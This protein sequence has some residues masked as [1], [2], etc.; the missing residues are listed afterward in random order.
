ME[1]RLQFDAAREGL[2]V[3]LAGI[4]P[5]GLAALRADAARETSGGNDRGCAGLH[6]RGPDAGAGGRTRCGPRR[7][8]RVGARRRSRRLRPGPEPPP[9]PGRLGSL[10]RRYHELGVSNPF[11]AQEYAEVR[12]RLETLDAQRADLEAAI[13]STRELIGTLNGLITRQFRADLCRAGGRLRA[14]VPAALRWGEAELSLT[15]PDDLSTT[16]VEITARPPGKKRQPLAMLSGGERA[17]TAVALLLAMLEVRPVPFCVLDEVDA[18]LD[19]ANI[20]RFS[21]AL[22]GL[23]ESIQFIVITHNRGTIE[24]ADALYGV[25]VGDDAVSHVVSLRLADRVAE[26]VAVPVPDAHAVATQAA[27]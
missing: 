14:A 6:R 21:S 5:D 4:G 23:A 10:R 20:G 15:A 3:E 13:H 18:A 27:E 19:E 25:T 2:L 22:R 8:A 11:A 17:L 7:L 24:A 16:G 26:P 1:V 9:S 12:A